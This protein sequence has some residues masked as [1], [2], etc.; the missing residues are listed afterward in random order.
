MPSDKVKYPKGGGP[1]NTEKKVLTGAL[2]DYCVTRIAFSVRKY[3]L[4]KEV[5]I[6]L[7]GEAL[8]P[9]GSESGQALK[10]IDQSMFENM[11]TRARKVLQ[12]RSVTG[13][14]EAR[15]ES[16]GF[17]ENMIADVTV[18]DKDR[19]KARENLDKIQRVVDQE[20][21]LIPGVIQHHVID[22]DKLDL[23][24]EQRKKL[25]EDARNNV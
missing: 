2:I 4:K 14:I 3:Q 6:I 16:I 25:L 21:T 15:Q 23:T 7:Y 20:G 24:L 5:S 19:M 8:N 22:I 17:Y 12:E 10:L 13:S 9:D 1:N 11:C 18:S